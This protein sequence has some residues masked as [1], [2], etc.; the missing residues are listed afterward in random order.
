MKCE[1]ITKTIYDEFWFNCDNLNSDWL[2]RFTWE[3]YD[4]DFIK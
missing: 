3:K 1:F 4:S 2:N